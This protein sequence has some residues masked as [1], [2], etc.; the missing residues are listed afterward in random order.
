[1][2]DTYVLLCHDCKIEIWIGQSSNNEIGFCFYSGEPE[3]MDDLKHFLWEHKRHQLSMD[4]SD[5]YDYRRFERK[6]KA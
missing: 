5:L 3:T 4:F 6:V 1:V 2:S